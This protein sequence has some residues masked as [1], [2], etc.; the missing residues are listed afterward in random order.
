MGETVKTLE[1]SV[2]KNSKIFIYKKPKEHKGE[3][4][5]GIIFERTNL[6]KAKM[7]QFKKQNA[8][9][10]N[11]NTVQ[12]TILLSKEGCNSLHLL[13]NKVVDMNFEI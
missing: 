11:A 2:N 7:K 12:N 9:I 13:L 6:S 8:D 4:Y 1:I 5:V 3:G 10:I